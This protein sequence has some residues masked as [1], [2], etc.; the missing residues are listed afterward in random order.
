MILPL[1]LATVQIVFIG[2]NF[3]CT[4]TRVWDGDGPV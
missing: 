3:R 1:L 2:E 4:P